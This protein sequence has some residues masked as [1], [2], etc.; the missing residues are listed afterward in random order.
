MTVSRADAS[1]ALADVAA[2]ENRSATL[3]GYQSAA[4]H[5][6]I[7]GVA[8]AA[9][10]VITDLAPRVANIA[11]LVILVFGTLADLAAA[12]L[13]RPQAENGAATG[14]VFLILIVFVG[15]TLAVMQPS[16]P[17]QTG[18]FIPLVAAAGY[19]VIGLMGAPRLLV[20]GSAMA[21]LTL[22]GFFLL[23]AHF[24]L[25]MAAVG[26]GSLVLGGVWLRHA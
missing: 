15:G 22:G 9:G 12:R 10:Y 2:A 5:L 16:D 6:I 20:L 7:W 19:A 23:P 11:W 17:R 25:W 8:W 4:P 26:G 1:A 18:A 3:R 21:V 14:M 13:D 24:L